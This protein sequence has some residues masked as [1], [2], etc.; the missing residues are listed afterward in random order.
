MSSYTALTEKA[1]TQ[2]LEA[3]QPLEELALT[4][5]TATRKAVSQAP[6]IPFADALP[7]PG[8]VLL[9]SAAFGERVLGA[10]KEFAQ[11]LVSATTP[12]AVVP[13][14]PSSAT[15]GAKAAAAAKA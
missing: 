12:A 5:A 9:A 14:Q 8:E 6:A 1:A 10:Q 11:R 7:T 2:L 15:T 3:V 13:S 4:L